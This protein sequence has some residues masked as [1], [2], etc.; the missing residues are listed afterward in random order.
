MAKGMT[1]SDIRESPRVLGVLISVFVVLLVILV[2]NNAGLQFLDLATYD[3][4]VSAKYSKPVPDPMAVLVRGTEE[5]ITALGEWPL[6]DQNLNKIFNQLTSAGARA[7]GL[8]IYRDMPVPPGTEALKETLLSNNRIIVVKKFP[9]ED[10]PGVKPPAYLAGTDRVGFTDTVVDSGGIVRRGLLFLDDEYGVSFGLS[11]RLALLYLADEGVWPQAGEP[12]PSFMRLGDVTLPPFEINDGPYINADA[13]GYQLLLSYSEGIDA[14]PVVTISELL[15]GEFPDGLFQDKIVLVGIAAE[16]V[17]DVFFTPFSNGLD[18]SQ[19][20]PGAMVH[21][22]LAS[23][24][25]RAGLDGQ[26]LLKTSSEEIENGWILLWGLLGCIIGLFVR[27]FPKLFVLTIAS[28]VVIMAASYLVFMEGWWLSMVAATGSLLA[29]V[30]LVT[31]YLSAYER[32]QRGLLMQLFSKHVSTD[33][34]DEI[35]KNR[36][37][38]FSLGRLRSQKLTITVLFTD[39]EHFTT[40]SEKLDPEALMDWLNEYMELMAN[41]VI[42]NG[43]V[44][45]DYHGDAIKADFGV[46]IA[47]TTEEGIKQD[48]ENAV[49]CALGMKQV[50]ESY[51]RQSREKGLPL[52]RMRVGISTGYV[53]AGCLGS[54]QR[55]KYTTI[56]DTVNTAARIETLDK[57][58][59]VSDT[60]VSDC[61]IL[62]AESTMHYIKD[63]VQAEPAGTV[64]L[65]GKTKPVEVFRI[66]HCASA[67]NGTLAT[68]EVTA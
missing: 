67:E 32:Q 13:A 31:A 54:S 64:I 40:I 62:L 51:N 37:Q 58:S 61:R 11:L 24:L 8:D 30:G 50:L 68:G 27:S 25:V 18:R 41:L 43:G 38:Y 39:I 45:D 21:A 36:E 63:T 19:A 10:S 7:I 65:R 23:Q 15:N 22:Y 46:P 44:V 3:L 42:T 49:K 56:G 2:R 34:A 66:D 5:D 53:V 29:T 1:L 6:S 52:L 17:K 4:L 59:C 16:S 14:I 9:S 47:R 20:M 60:E 26:Q 35:W 12:D 28:A 33:V 48:A 55:M 57:E